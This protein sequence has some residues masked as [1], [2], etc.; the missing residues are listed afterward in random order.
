MTTLEEL[1]TL[2][3]LEEIILKDGPVFDL[4]I[5]GGGPAGLTAAIYAGRAKI[6]TLLIEK[7]L[8]GGM[9]STTYMIENY[10]GFPD[11]ITGMDLAQHLEMH[12]RKFGTDIYYGEVD[13]IR[14]EKNKKIVEI[15]GKHLE[16]RALI[17]ASG[18][19]PKKLGIPGEQ[20]LLGR[21]VSYCATCDGAFYKNKNIVVVGGGNAAVEE[22]LFL[23]RYAGKIS[24]IHR[25]DQLRADKILA[26][27]ALNDPKIFLV[28]NTEVESI[29]GEK[30][31]EEVKV[32][33]KH[34]DKVSFIK[35]EGVFIYV[36]NNPNTAYLPENIKRDKDGYLVTDAEL[37]T[38]EEGVFAAGDI[39]SKSLRQVATAVGDGALAAEAARKYIEN[40]HK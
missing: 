23:T 22:A 8:L 17:L 25:R 12:A 7:A 19:E 20:K 3:K 35:T 32:R 10:P 16:C 26:E 13:A 31:V 29:E 14:S 11:G 24:I 9:A 4:I 33:N 38:S 37:K 15:E 39:R 28:W 1:H 30:R 6:K 27:R 5:I 21:G 2:P 34:T 36:G 40:S 18:S